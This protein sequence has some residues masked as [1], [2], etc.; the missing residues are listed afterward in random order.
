MCF[1]SKTQKALYSDESTNQTSPPATKA[2]APAASSSSTSPNDSSM[3]PHVAIIIYTLYGHI[4][5]LA[6]AEKRGVEAAGGKVTIYQV[7]ETLP[8]EVLTKM[9]APPK[10]NYPIITPAELANFDAF[11]FGIPTRYG[12]VPA[13]IKAFFDATGHLWQQGKLYGKFA[14]VFT[15]VSVL[16]TFAHHGISFVPLG[17][18]PAFAQLANVTEPHGGSPWGAGT[19]ASADGSRQPTPLELELAEIQGKSFYTQVSRAFK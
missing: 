13:Q 14:G 4:A 17:Y 12:S 9:H 18:A 3:A 5:K 16:S 8:Q 11:I 1:P 19:L 10:P 6:E 7:A 2:Q 15:V